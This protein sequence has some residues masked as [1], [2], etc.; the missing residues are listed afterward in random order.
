M[1]DVINLRRA[2]KRKHEATEAIAAAQNRIDFGLRKS[3]RERHAF[4]ASRAAA[5]LDGHL[6]QA[7]PDQRTIM[8]ARPTDDAEA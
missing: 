6:R 8:P 3:E 5:R 1:S 4:D 2:R 7:L